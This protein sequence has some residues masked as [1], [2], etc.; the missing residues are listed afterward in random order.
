M[1][2]TLMMLNVA[3][4]RTGALP[5]FPDSTWLGQEEIEDAARVAGPPLSGHTGGYAKLTASQVS[6]V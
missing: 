4:G 5:G 2:L 3:T 1:V 6:T